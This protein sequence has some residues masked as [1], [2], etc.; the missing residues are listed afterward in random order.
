MQ[1][2]D[3]Q[4]AASLL[5]IAENSADSFLITDR[6]GTIVYVNPAFERDSGFT[7]DEVVGRNPRIL[8]SGN[9]DLSLIH[10]SEPTR[11]Y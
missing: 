3:Q 2:L 4:I 7:R 1:A 10:I 9:H 8:K 6:R 5:G 11:P